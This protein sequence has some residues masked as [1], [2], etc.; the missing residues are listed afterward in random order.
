MFFQTLVD[1]LPDWVVEGAMSAVC[2]LVLYIDECWEKYERMKGPWN[3]LTFDDE[4]TKYIEEIGI[5][6]NT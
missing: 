1:F 6:I 5:H 2:D 3:D 4:R